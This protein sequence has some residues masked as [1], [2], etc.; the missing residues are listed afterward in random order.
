MKNNFL[1]STIIL[2]IGGFL[3]K[4]LGLIIKII[5][6]RIIKE[7]GIALYSL[8][9]PTYS[10][11]IS[12]ANF[13]IQL[14]VSKKISSKESSKKVLIN[15]SYIMILL[16]AILISLTLIFAKTI[17]LNLLKNK[18]TFLPLIACSLTLPFISIGYI[19]KGY[20]YGKQNMTPHMISNVL[21]QLLRLLIISLLLPKITKYGP[22]ITIT[23]FI[24]IS[25]ITETFSI[26]ILLI[27]IPKKFTIK[28]EDLIYSKE[29]IK[30]LL[31]ITIPSISGRLI[32]NLGYFLEP[33]LLTNILLNKGFT[34]TYIANE[35]GI[36]N[37]YAISTL[38]FPS[39]FITAISNSLLPEISKLRAER[40]KKKTIKRINESII[41]SFITGLIC[42]GIIYIFKKNILLILYKTTKGINYLN[43]LT[44]FFILFYLESPL[45]TTLIALNKIKTCTFISVTGIILKL[46][47]M[48]LFCLLNYGMNSLVISEIINIIYVT[49]LDII[50]LKKE[51]KNT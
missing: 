50:F 8:I 10:L 4:I 22:I 26:I 6:I 25:I 49:I 47:I 45:S 42:T 24:L 14:A 51:L 21:E 28:K 23:I 46:L 30:S 1:K 18:S 33:I 7:E 38:L 43:I 34:S 20:F 35:Y 19:I 41:L 9:M 17:S 27:F 29:E 40:N 44:P 13:N 2:L 37:T 15:A 48:S 36:Y 12:I 11:L 32:G 5:Y 3:T 39:F 16:N 31:S